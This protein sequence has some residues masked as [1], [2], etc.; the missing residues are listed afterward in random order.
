MNSSASNVRT[1]FNAW[2]ESNEHGPGQTKH[3]VLIDIISF[4]IDDRTVDIEEFK[5]EL[6]DLYDEGDD[7]CVERR[8]FPR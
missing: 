3:D 2:W 7:E 5:K 1:V 4:F 6:Y 8:D